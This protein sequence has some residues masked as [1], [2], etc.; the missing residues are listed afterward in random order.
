MLKNGF[1]ADAWQLALIVLIFFI[2]LYWAYRKD[3]KL[4]KKVKERTEDIGRS[5][6]KN[7]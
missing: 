6:H 4:M 3:H 7:F 5:G 2:L 1:L